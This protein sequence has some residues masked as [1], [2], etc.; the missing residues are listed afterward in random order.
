[1]KGMEK[2]SEAILDKVKMEA[3]QIVKEAE[4]KALQGIEKAEKEI[5]AKFEEGVGQY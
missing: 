3:Q 1:M 2:I 5:E 4:E